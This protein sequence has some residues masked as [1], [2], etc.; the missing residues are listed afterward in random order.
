M[1]AQDSQATRRGAI[2]RVARD[3]ADAMRLH[4]RGQRQG[5]GATWGRTQ[6]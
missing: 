4:G 3:A 1:S 5:A 2:G 6:A